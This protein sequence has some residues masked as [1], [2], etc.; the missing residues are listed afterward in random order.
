MSLL[1]LVSYG[2]GLIFF[3]VTGIVLCFGFNMRIMLIIHWCLFMLFNV[4]NTLIYSA[5]AK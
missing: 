1:V 5:V 4:D 2:T 3:L